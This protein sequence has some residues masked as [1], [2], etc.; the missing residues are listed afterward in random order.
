MKQ[1]LIKFLQKLVSN[2]TVFLK[3]KDTVMCSPSEHLF[4][5]RSYLYTHLSSKLHLPILDVGAADGKTACYFN[6]HFPKSD[7]IAYEPIPAMFEIACKNTGGK[8]KITVR[9]LA[10]SDKKG[11]QQIHVTSNYLS[12]SL[13]ELNAS[14]IQEQAE[15]MQDKMKVLQTLTIQT[16][17]L[18]EETSNLKELLFI[19]LDTQGTELSIL[20][21][22][23]QTLRKTHVVLVEMNNHRLYTNGC[24]YYEVDALLREAG[25]KL[26][27][28]IVTYRPKG[29]MEEYD[30]LYRNT[31]L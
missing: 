22:G 31:S 18:D 23:L 8:P 15:S 25:F 27:D 24:Q 14:A 7:I 11:T 12:S 29:Q 5:L 30:A 2:E 19:K 16:S 6:E 21:H 26:E 28:M 3:T 4:R 17:T 10:L 1:L 13:N 9:N 20:K